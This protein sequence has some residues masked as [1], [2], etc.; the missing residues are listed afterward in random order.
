MAVRRNGFKEVYMM[1]PG[2][3]HECYSKYS[4]ICIGHAALHEPVI[5]NARSEWRGGLELWNPNS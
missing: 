1:S 4:Y 5:L 3:Q 2:S